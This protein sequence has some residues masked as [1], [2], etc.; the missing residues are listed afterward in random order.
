ME[1]ELITTEEFVEKVRDGI[2]TFG[3][4]VH[5]HEDDFPE[6]MSME[7]WMEEFTKFVVEDG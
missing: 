1:S 3:Q 5:A 2:F 7:E 6:N 4:F